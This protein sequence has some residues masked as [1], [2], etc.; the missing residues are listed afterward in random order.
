[1][2][3]DSVST[4]WGPARREYEF[5]HI[6][7]QVRSPLKAIP[8]MQALKEPSWRYICQWTPCRLDEPPILRAAKYWYYWNLH[9]EKIAQWRYRIED[10]RYVYYEFCHRLGIPANPTVLDSLATDINTRAYGRALHLYD[11]ACLKV[12]V[13]PSGT[14]RALLSRR[15]TES[16]DAR[17]TWSVLEALDAEL[18]RLVKTKAAQYGYPTEHG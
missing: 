17:F 7:H 10:L 18:A 13:S 11:E 6:F 15:K 8:S 12:G 3:V 14:M 1:M 9:A 5:E 16:Q 4:P 2:A